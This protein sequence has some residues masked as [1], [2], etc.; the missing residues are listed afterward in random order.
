M[1]ADKDLISIQE[2]R[3]LLEEAK[4]A[5]RKLVEYSQEQLNA[6]FDSIIVRLVPHLQSL[7]IMSQEETG[8]GKWQDKYIKNRF[9]CEEIANALRPQ[10]YIGRIA[11]QNDGKVFEIGVPLGVIVSAVSVLSPVSTTIYN[12]LLAI[13]SG[14]ALVFS[15]HP[16]AKRS[17]KYVLDIMIEA[18][19]SA[20][21]PKHCLSYLE[22]VSEA[23]TEALFN[24]TATSALLLSNV[25][26][27]LNSAIK[28]GKAYIYS[29]TGQGPVFIEKS[30]HL[31]KAINAIIL[32]K[33]FDNGTMSSAENCLILDAHIAEQA[34]ILLKQKKC[35]FLSDEEAQKLACILFS[36]NG[37]RNP[38]SVGLC[39]VE[40][41]KKAGFSVP[42]DTSLLIV[43]RIYVRDNDPYLKELFAPVLTCYVEDDW[44]NACE[45]CI[46]LLL[47][48]TKSHT[49]TIHSNDQA[50]I[51]LFALKK[52]VARLLVNTPAIFGA[53]GFSTNL[54]PSLNLASVGNSN[55]NLALFS[56]NLSPRYLTN[57]RKVAFGSQ[58]AQ[59]STQNVFKEE[60]VNVNNKLDGLSVLEKL[61]NR[62]LL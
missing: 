47:V 3:I 7:A 52:P 5:H 39:A 20:G 13:K 22:N 53:M 26:G 12:T 43:D 45:K 34:K 6:I 15:L 31:E 51:E 38:A 49:L 40:L 14:N 28:S 41:A 37:K 23:G 21:L 33:T 56:D 29:G 48:E 17:M 4:R 62:T 35:Y 8:Y 19:T 60:R 30:A 18:A 50:V 36:H 9:V 42:S 2:A 55:S 58:K 61:L 59:I 11:C 44:Q 24:H 57:R 54:F 16:R 1:I 32:S 46:E 10:Q 27:M 25:S